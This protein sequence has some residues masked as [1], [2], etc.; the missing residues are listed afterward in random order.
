[1]TY[2]CSLE[3]REGL[4]VTRFISKKEKCMLL[5]SM[6]ISNNIKNKNATVPGPLCL[7]NN[8]NRHFNTHQTRVLNGFP[9]V[10]S[11]EFLSPFSS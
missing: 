3:L 9:T 10:I 7:S 4:K 2:F 8:P 11:F 6:T 1:M 5:A